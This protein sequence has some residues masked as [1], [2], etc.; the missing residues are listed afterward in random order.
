MVSPNN[1]KSL[2]DITTDSQL[3]SGWFD[4]NS[5]GA[6]NVDTL[7][8]ALDVPITWGGRN[9]EDYLVKIREIQA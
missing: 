4:L 8:I 9:V 6:C 5:N 7:D 1:T 2:Q 3:F